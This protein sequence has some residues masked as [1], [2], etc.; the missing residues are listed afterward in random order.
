MSGARFLKSFSKKVCFVKLFNT[1]DGL[2]I[3]EVHCGRVTFRGKRKWYTVIGI[4]L[5]AIQQK[6]LQ[7]FFHQQFLLLFLSFYMQKFLT[8]I[9]Y[10][11]KLFFCWLREAELRFNSGSKSFKTTIHKLNF[12]EKFKFLKIATSSTAKRI[13]SS[14][15]L[16]CKC[17]ESLNC[18]LQQGAL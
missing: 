4:R 17:S 18:L 10:F 2:A 3:F 13:F 7:L 16:C 1:I 11:H 14:F 8:T 15:F 6:C 12:F 9:V 5:N